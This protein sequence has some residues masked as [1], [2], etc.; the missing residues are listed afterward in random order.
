MPVSPPPRPVGED[1][2]PDDDPVQA[3]LRNELFLSRFVPEIE[4]EDDGNHKEG[5]VQTHAPGAAPEPEGRFA[6]EPS[7]TVPLHRSQHVP[8]A[9][10]QNACR[11]KEPPVSESRQDRILVLHGG[12]ERALVEN[13]ARDDPEPDVLHLKRLR[14]THERRHDMAAFQSLGD[15]LPPGAPRGPDNQHACECP[16]GWLA[17]TWARRPE[18]GPAQRKRQEHCIDDEYGEERDH[19]AR[20]VR[21]AINAGSCAVSTAVHAIAGAPPCSARP[22]AAAATGAHAIAVPIDRAAMMV[23]PHAWPMPGR[24]SYSAQMPFSW[25]AGFSSMS[26]PV[27]CKP[28]HSARARK[29]AMRPAALMVRRTRT[30]TR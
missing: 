6:D 4:R 22:A 20:P 28:L 19:A 12:I 8:R 27:Y 15:Q 7:D 26:E 11:T 1:G 9:V 25:S 29:T 2:G 16:A 18:S 10:G 5:V 17:R 30:E 3:A 24:Q 23:C 13:I 14:I 21:L